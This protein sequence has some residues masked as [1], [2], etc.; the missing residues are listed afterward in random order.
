MNDMDNISIVNR[1][2]VKNINYY[3]GNH[4]SAK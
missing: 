4:E 3:G 1:E 2:L